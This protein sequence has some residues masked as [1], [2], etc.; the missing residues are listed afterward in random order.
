M[1]CVCCG[2]Y[3]IV[4]CCCC[5]Q[6]SEGRGFDAPDGVHYGDSV[7]NVGFQMFANAALGNAVPSTSNDTV[8]RNRVLLP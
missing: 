6:V 3:D 5:Q 8:C 7:Y 2:L 1:L 4:V